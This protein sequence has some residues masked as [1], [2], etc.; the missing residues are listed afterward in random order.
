MPID[1]WYDYDGDLISKEEGKKLVAKQLIRQDIIKDVSIT[2]RHIVLGHPCLRACNCLA[3][4]FENKILGGAL[5]GE[6]YRY[7]NIDEALDGHQQR[8]NLIKLI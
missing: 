4:C 1:K 8:V 6:I 7:H 3:A 5:D 2:T